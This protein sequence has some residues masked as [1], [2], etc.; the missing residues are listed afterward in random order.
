MG[1]R[2][3]K[4]GHM[5]VNQDWRVAPIGRV[6]SG[7]VVCAAGKRKLGVC[8]GASNYR[9]ALLFKTLCFAVCDLFCSLMHV[10]QYAGFQ[11]RLV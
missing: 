1:N 5:S 10:C 2:T 9:K 8:I 6:F 3:I 11:I 4:H 7:A